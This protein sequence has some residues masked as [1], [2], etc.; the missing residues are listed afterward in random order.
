MEA[1]CTSRSETLN[2]HTVSISDS[3][4]GIPHQLTENDVYEGYHIP[5]GSFVFANSWYVSNILHCRNILN[6]SFFC[7]AML[8]DEELYPDP[9]F[10]KPERFLTKDGRLNRDVRDP[11]MVAFGF[12]RRFVVWSCV[13]PVQG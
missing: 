11:S 2:S 1:S 7:R 5:K 3:L 4:A 10:F 13:R 9:S 6:V 8:H 12:G